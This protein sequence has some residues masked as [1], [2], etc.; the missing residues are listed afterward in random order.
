MFQGLKPIDNEIYHKPFP[1]A[2][3]TN[4]KLIKELESSGYSFVYIGDEADARLFEEK[5]VISNYAY[6]SS[7]IRCVKLASETFGF[8]KTSMCNSS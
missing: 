6:S 7:C 2:S 3:S 1:A 4:S 5:Y 8:R